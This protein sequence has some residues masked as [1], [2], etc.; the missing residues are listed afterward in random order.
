MTH[1]LP[2]LVSIIIPA[3]NPG[4]Y[5]S[6]TL[7]SVL[8]QS[9]RE[10]EVI[11]VDDGSTDEWDK[12]YHCINDARIKLVKFES[13]QGIVP[14]LNAGLTHARGEF[15]CRIDADDVM[16]KDRITK[17]VE[18]MG[19]YPDVDVVG[20]NYSTI[21]KYGN[22]ISDFKLPLSSWSIDMHLC[23]FGYVAVGH[24]FTMIRRKAIQEVNGYLEKYNRLGME[25]FDLWLRMR[26]AGS[27]FMNSR[28]HLTQYRVHNKQSTASISEATL[29]AKKK[30]WDDFLEKNLGAGAY[31]QQRNWVLGSL[32]SLLSLPIQRCY[33]LLRLRERSKTAY[34]SLPF[35]FLGSLSLSLLR[36]IKNAIYK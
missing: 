7:D 16:S 8:H 13:N 30:A 36:L 19:A 28:E 15:I 1:D 31:M 35:V 3:Y 17:Q 21:D 6:E 23:V 34:L 29:E 24:P 20:S 26:A 33:L 5:I 18:L 4:A 2:R 27:Q 14:A 32:A 25:D 12:H 9:Y 10:I 22:F 11:V